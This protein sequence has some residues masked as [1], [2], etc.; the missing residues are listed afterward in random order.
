MA[1][2]KQINGGIETYSV[3][4]VANKGPSGLRQTIISIYYLG[5]QC[6]SW[7]WKTTFDAAWVRVD[8]VTE[9]DIQLHEMLYPNSV[10]LLRLCSE[11]D[12]DVI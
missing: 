3:A 10:G 1:I 4:N 9:E 11:L 5:D 6:V 2:Y 12:E 7:I 8:F